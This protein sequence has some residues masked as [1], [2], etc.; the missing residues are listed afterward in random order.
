M[1]K[2]WTA[3]ASLRVENVGINDL[4]AGDPVDYTSVEGNNF[5]V[6]FGGRL[7]YDDRD[8]VLRATE[9]S[10]LD[11]SY[12]EC[13]GSYTFPLVNLDYDKYFTVWQRPDGSGR[14]VLA[15]HSA[16][17]WAGDDTPV[18]E[19]F[20][21]GGF[22]SMRGFE[23]R[24]VGP[25]V[26]ANGVTYE[27]GGDFLLLNS[28]EYQIPL[29]AKDAIYAVGFVDTGTVRVEHRDQGLPRVGRF[30][31]AD[32][33]AD[34]GPGADRPGLRLPDREGAAGPN[35]SLQLLAGLLPLTTTEN[36]ENTEKKRS[37]LFFSV[38]SVSSVVS[39]WRRA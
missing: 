34:V 18:Y 7:T 14:Q 36:T 6:G 37:D 27:T 11:I 8:S 15:L 24:G 31:P 29:V 30:R 13:T 26:Q 12:E 21:G 10:Q 20:F 5:L 25:A 16:V 9:G 2:Y 22:R 38:F 28:L 33:G 32:R 1:D 35:S 4:E 3:S 19:R 39:R 17:G 23:F